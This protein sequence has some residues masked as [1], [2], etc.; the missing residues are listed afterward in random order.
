[1]VDYYLLLVDVGRERE[2]MV[3][4]LLEWWLRVGWSSIVNV[5]AG[6]GGSFDEASKENS[7]SVENENCCHAVFVLNFV[8]D[9]SG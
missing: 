1:V 6:G 5:V 9:C 3:V 7:Q 2:S 4:L 8:R